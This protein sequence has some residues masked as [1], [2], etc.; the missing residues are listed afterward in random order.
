MP[1]LTLLLSLSTLVFA[2]C[3]NSSTSGVRD[4]GGESKLHYE[5]AVLFSAPDETGVGHV[6]FK[7]CQPNTEIN[8]FC[9][10]MGVSIKLDEKTTYQ[11]K[12]SL[13]D[14]EVL[15]PVDRRKE[16]L[17][18][19]TAGR[20]YKSDDKDR[21]LLFK[22]FGWPFAEGDDN[23]A[24]PTTSSCD[25]GYVLVPKN[26]EVGANEDFCVMKYEAKIKG[27]EDG[28]VDDYDSS[29]RA[30]SRAS[31]TPWVRIDRDEAIE[32]CGN[33]GA[34]LI[35]NAQWQAIARN[36][37]GVAANWSRG[38]VGDGSLNRGHSNG[39]S[40]LAASGDEGGSWSVNKRTHTLNNGEIIW[41]LAGNVWEWVKDNNTSKQGLN[42]YVAAE[43]WSNESSKVKW[44]P[45]GS[46]KH[47]NSGE[48][49]GLGYSWLKY[50]AGAVLRGGDWGDG[51]DAGVF[52]ALLFG[53][54]SD[55]FSSIGFRCVRALR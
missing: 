53:G 10:S 55:S 52:Y 1:R 47:L 50:D 29:Y 12:L 34:E 15:L 5:K 3:K 45:K 39:S 16:I 43:P 7:V 19:L 40:A 2:S 32:A 42:S 38:K 18:K 14:Y 31:G 48:R 22:P 6:F 27:M 33:V 26:A 44:G 36:I 51:G 24:P 20:D 28:K 21:E 23:P 54:P 13:R 37:E 11:K 35:S 9:A 30:E 49:G 46:Y 17:T 8:R 41:D 25:E 4:I